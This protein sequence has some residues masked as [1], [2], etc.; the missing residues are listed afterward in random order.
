ML[1]V[2]EINL[3][4]PDRKE[5]CSVS[6][7]LFCWQTQ[8]Y[9]LRWSSQASDCY[10]PTNSAS[11]GWRKSINNT[12]LS[13]VA[14]T[15]S[16]AGSLRA[17]SPFKGIARSHA[18]AARDQRDAT[19]PQPVSLA[20]MKCLLAGYNTVEGKPQIVKYLGKEMGASSSIIS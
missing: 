11:Q 19:F 13:S 7:V 5:C 10:K 17:S 20:L 3:T 14:V 15:Q 6:M 8:Q 2:Y 18:G 4:I 16:Y 12:I 9:Q 1:F